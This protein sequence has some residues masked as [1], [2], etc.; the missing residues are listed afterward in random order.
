M[1]PRRGGD[2]RI[3]Q[4][5]R[6]EAAQAFGKLD[7]F[8]QRNVGESAE[9]LEV[10]A[11]DEDRLIAEERSETLI[12]P[13]FD[14]FDPAAVRVAC[15]EFP[16]ERAA[17]RI[18]ENGERLHMRARQVGVGVMK[19]QPLPDRVPRAEIHLASAIGSPGAEAE[20][21]CGFHRAAMFRRLV[22]TRDDDFADLRPAG[23]RAE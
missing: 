20:R 14:P 9:L 17:H 18:V 10:L 4:R 2:R 3:E 7:V 6:A 1:S 12:A 13:A 22:G 21:A 16:M 19:E 15:V 5:E 23:N 8:H 11:P